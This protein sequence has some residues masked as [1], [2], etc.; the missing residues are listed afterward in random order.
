MDEKMTGIFGAA[1][2]D[3]QQYVKNQLLKK[4]GMMPRPEP[5]I[6]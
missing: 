6:P 4:P 1:M 3:G 5:S 2:I